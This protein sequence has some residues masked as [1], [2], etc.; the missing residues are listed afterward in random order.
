[1]PRAAQ[2][3]GCVHLV[4]PPDAMADAL[5]SYVNQALSPQDFAE[6]VFVPPRLGGM[7]TIFQM[8]REEYGIDFSYYKPNTVVR[9]I[10]RRVSMSKAETIDDYVEQLKTDH[11]E[12]NALYRDL[13]IGVTGKRSTTWRLTCCLN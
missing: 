13:L 9:R 2:E 5:V 3:T 7:E 11:D 12:L 8:L 4:L 1:M 10:E 6:K